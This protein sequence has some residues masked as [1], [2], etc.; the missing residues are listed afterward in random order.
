MHRTFIFCD[1]CGKQKPTDPHNGL[2]ANFYR[3]DAFASISIPGNRTTSAV[4]ASL[5][6]TKC[7][8]TWVEKQKEF[9]CEGLVNILNKDAD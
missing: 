9:Q 1:E 6:S 7:I 4:S 2:M 5:C 8:K 3:E